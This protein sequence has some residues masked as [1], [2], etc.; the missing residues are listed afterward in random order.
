MSALINS[1]FY[2]GRVNH[3][4]LSPVKHGFDYP[5]MMLALDLD[6]L[7]LV[8]GISRY[9]SVDKFAPLSFYQADYLPHQAR[10]DGLKSRVLAQVKHLGGQ[11]CQRVLFIGQGRHFGFYFSPINCFFC[12][13][14]EQLKYL[15][16]EVSNT[17][18]NERHYYLIDMT[19]S[20]QLT[21]KAFHVSPFMTLDMQYQWRVSAPK[22]EFKLMINNLN[23]NKIFTAAMLLQQ[24][25]FSSKQVLKALMQFP[26]MTFSIVSKIYWQALKLWLKRVPFV[27]HPTQGKE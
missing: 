22:Q 24:Q 8:D 2:Y 18:W 19:Q 3:Q 17:P 23:P 10:L 27:V 14:G 12:Y 15:L 20:S 11:D 6:E 5:I 16:A 1:H 7:E 26:L 25:A 13:Q 9:F 21:D 4:R